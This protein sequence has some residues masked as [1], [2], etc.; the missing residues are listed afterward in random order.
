M[1]PRHTPGHMTVLVSSQ[2]KRALLRGDVITW[3][4]QL[5]SRLGRRLVRSTPTSPHGSG[6]VS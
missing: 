1:T 6:A 2:G 4:V 3:P 5:V